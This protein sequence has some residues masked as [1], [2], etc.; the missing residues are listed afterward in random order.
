MTD[1]VLVRRR[2]W[3]RRPDL[4]PG[5][6]EQIFAEATGP[7]FVGERT[8]DEI[9]QRIATDDRSRRGRHRRAHGGLD[10]YG[11]E[12]LDPILSELVAESPVGPSRGCPLQRRSGLARGHG[13]EVR[14]ARDG[15]PDG[16]LG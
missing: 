8:E 4:P 13:S 1:V 10:F 16:D 9:R 7:A 14:D 2:A 6:L 12:Y 11:H 3:E 15:R 5:Q